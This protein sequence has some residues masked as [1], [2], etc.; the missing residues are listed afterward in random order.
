LIK[1]LGISSSSG[2]TTVLGAISVKPKLVNT[3][4]FSSS[5]NSCSVFNKILSY[6]SNLIKS[7]ILILSIPLPILILL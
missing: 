6:P 1:T 2:S 4:R 7:K 3:T 5:V